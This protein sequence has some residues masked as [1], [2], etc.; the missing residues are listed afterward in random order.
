MRTHVVVYFI[1]HIHYVHYR[2]SLYT[3][4]VSCIYI[5]HIHYESLYLSHCSQGAE[6]VICVCECLTRVRA[7]KAPSALPHF[8]RE[9]LSRL[10]MEDELNMW[11]AQMSCTHLDSM[12]VC[13]L[14]V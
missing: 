13:V 8:T 6:C 3:V 7:G 2:H 9:V 5:L 11:C 10:E 12:F 4:Y 14:L 1:N